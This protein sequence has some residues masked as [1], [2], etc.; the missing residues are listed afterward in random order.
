[1]FY[2][3]W[4][5][6]PLLVLKRPGVAVA[7][8][9]ATIVGVLPAAGTPLFVS[10]SQSASIEQQLDDQCV[11]P[12]AAEVRFTEQGDSTDERDGDVV[13]R[14][15]SGPSPEAVAAEVDDIEAQFAEIGDVAPVERTFVLGHP[16]GDEF[17]RDY[18]L[19]SP[20]GDSQRV[21]IAY[22]DGATDLIG[23]AVG[24]GGEGAWIP[25]DLSIGLEPGDTA[26]LHQETAWDSESAP[27]EPP[28]GA[29]DMTITYTE[30][31]E[32]TGVALPVAGD[33]RS[34]ND[35]PVAEE[36]WCYLQD[37]LQFDAMPEGEWAPTVL[38]DEES[39]WTLGRQAGADVTVILRYEL[40]TVPTLD[41]AH[42]QAE[43]LKK[44]D[45][46]VGGVL[47]TAGMRTDMPRFVERAELVGTSLRLPVSI[48]TGTAV[49]VGLCI[50]G[51]AGVMWVRRRSVE[52][53]VL[54]GRGVSATALG[55][56][57]A[58][59]AF[60]AVAVGAVVG[61]LLSLWS[62]PWWAPVENVDEGAS[63]WSI[64][65]AV[66]AALLGL[67]VVG[68]ASGCATRRLTE[69]VTART[70]R[71]DFVP[72][73]LIPVGGAAAAWFF[74][75]DSLIVTADA[76][77]ERVGQVVQLP[78]RVFVVPLLMGVACA[79]LAARLVRWWW[80][81]LKS[82]PSSVSGF[83]ASGRIRRD[84]LASAVM[85]AAV[86][87]PTALAGYA[88]TASSSVAA[89]IDAQARSEIGSDVVVTF[90]EPTGVD[91]RL[92][93]LGV[94]TSVVRVDSLSLDG[95]KVSTLFVDVD[96][97]TRAADTAPM[98]ADVD[99]AEA[100]SRSN[101][102]GVPAL[103]VGSGKITDGEATVGLPGPST[104]DVNVTTVPDLPGGR[105][106]NPVVLI[107]DEH[108]PELSWSNGYQW[109]VRTDD[110]AAVREF[111]ESQYETAGV[112]LAD[113]RY[114]GTPKHALTASIEYLLWV[115]VLTAVVVIVGVLLRW[116]SQS[117]ANRRAFVLM[118]R[119]G[120]RSSS[121]RLVLFREIG[122]LLG[123]G[124]AFGAV[125]AAMLVVGMFP[126]F[127][128]DPGSGPGV[129]VTVP[130]T[131][132]GWLAG[133]AVVTIGLAGLLTHARIA[134]AEPWLV[135]RDTG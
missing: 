22:R 94:A 23:P 32:P 28:D 5:K 25:D 74:M 75:D 81:R 37:M 51:A 70:R 63:V 50:M 95:I 122:I 79:V 104:M 21:Y 26:E 78:G 30:G 33:Y 121:H 8:L 114:D 82:R 19:A 41:E 46:S 101:D 9:V 98:M 135:L 96:S 68:L 39:F 36:H 67:L 102:G 111:V 48:L 89:T 31:S 106:G 84:R 116:E 117:G 49:L 40:T 18:R 128:V 99:I 4:V 54:A 127:D 35:S 92:S 100:L 86:A 53:N 132:V 129:L 109:W 83:I 88:V 71:L 113:E 16:G 60:P 58:L 42:R 73:E 64:G 2:P 45:E 57:G 119:M 124:M 1:M 126:D 133:A 105:A 77:S 112:A 10:A 20:D 11:L 103:A 43:Q 123:T 65:F 72:W 93:A 118:R 17:S 91:E 15:V 110:P 6:A 34:L 56:K 38:L 130:V 59:E 24:P 125:I 69:P 13:T 115:S 120:L 44:V 47:G 55:V 134:A 52:L 131:V 85:V 14:V 108:L 12:G 80:G 3:P 7:L 61:Y 87:V 27:G 107:S 97:F 66:G 62:M 29:P 90:D 76:G